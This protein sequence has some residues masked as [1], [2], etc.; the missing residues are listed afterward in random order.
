[1]NGV[2][3]ALVILL[4]ACALRGWWRGFFRECFGL[5][6]LIAAVAAALQFAGVGETVLEPYLG[7]P[8]PVRA[9]VAFV[10]IFVAVHTVVNVVGVLL[11]R[12]DSTT[13]LLGVNVFAGAL[14]GAGKAAV[15]LAF[16]LLFLHLFPLISALEPQIMSSAIG[17]PLV[18]AASNAIRI[19]TQPGP[20]RRT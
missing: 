6:A 1:M 7:L 13:L 5:L 11:N 10:V 8:S 18:A 17:R 15:A 3:L 9:G 20:A 4:A 12:L 14:F 19:G 16:V 2:D